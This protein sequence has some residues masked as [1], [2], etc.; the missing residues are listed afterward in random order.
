MLVIQTECTMMPGLVGVRTLI[1]LPFPRAVCVSY[2]A[3]YLH[4]HSA[5]IQ[6]ET[7]ARYR[8][9]A[10]RSGNSPP[11]LPLE[12]LSST[13][14]ADASILPPANYPAGFRR[15]RAGTLPSNVQLA[16]Q[17]Y[18]STLTHATPSMEMTNAPPPPQASST[19]TR[20][21]IRHASTTATPSLP[22]EHNVINNSRLRS[23][24]LSTLPPTGIS[25]SNNTTAFGSSLYSSS[26]LNNQGGYP[27]LDELR[28]VSNES[29]PG[30]DVHTL[31]YLGLDDRARPPPATVSEL[32]TQAQAAIA[33]RLRATTV[34]NP[35][36]NRPP[37]QVLAGTG[38]EDDLQ[39]VEEYETQ[40]PYRSRVDS[41][42][43]GVYYNSTNPYVAKGFKQTSH[44][45]VASRPRATSVGTLEDPNRARY[46]EL[47]SLLPQSSI[48]AANAN[49]ILRSLAEPKAQAP[50]AR[51]GTQLNN[52]RFTPG[53]VTTQNQTRMSLQTS[54]LQPP[55]GQSQPRSLSPN[56]ESPQ[57]QTP[58]RSLWIGNLDSTATKETLLTVFSP[59]GAIES[60]RLLPEKECGFVNFLDIN[61]AIR[62][63]DDVLNRLGGNIGLPNGQPV[64]IG[65]GKADSAP[66]QP[67]KTPASA[68]PGGGPTTV[69]GMEVQSTPTRALWIG[70]IPSSTTPATILSLFA[71]YGPIE[72][73]RV[74]THKNCG[75][76][77]WEHPL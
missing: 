59:Y 75:F 67:A 46:A 40:G 18:A 45:G 16:A 23:G 73:A 25:T 33:G 7:G 57:I 1:P 63:K 53:D 9:P 8:P 42:D 4:P 38:T 56:R 32:R 41:F 61:D 52:I 29:V 70:S 3:L 47:N 30:D 14:A 48:N 37:L 39:E 58:S 71:P 24:S 36:R 20:P 2:Q 15:A 19:L 65:F 62:A 12:D 55:Q 21:S 44:L 74:L 43:T 34:S 69:G 10:L 72:S 6:P 28:S 11:N 13:T 5:Q 26:W 66:A 17:R 54:F 27:V 68:A 64:R 51:L 76:G 50:P 31:D 22:G 77:Q 35:Y 60:L 49:S